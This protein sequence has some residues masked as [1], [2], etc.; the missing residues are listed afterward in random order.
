MRYFQP[1]DLARP[2]PPVALSWK[3]PKG[4]EEVLNFFGKGGRLPP[5]PQNDRPS[6]S[7]S[8]SVNEIGKWLPDT[9][10]GKVRLHPDP[11]DSLEVEH[12]GGRTDKHGQFALAVDDCR[13]NPDDLFASAQAAE[14]AGDIAA[15]RSAVPRQ[16]RH[17]QLYRAFWGNA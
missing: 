7:P 14:Q 11:C 2:Q 17:G 10:L 16:G 6:S 15:G 8:S 5:L 3:S 13:H 1:Y 9:G 12:S 4:T